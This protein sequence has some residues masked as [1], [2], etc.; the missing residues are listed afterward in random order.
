MNRVVRFTKMHGLGNDFMI[1]HDHDLFHH[2]ETPFDIKALADRH[3][4]VGFDQ[5]LIFIKHDALEFECRI[6]NS[7]GSEALQCG[8]GLRCVARFIHEN[9]LTDTK[10]F[11]IKT[12]AGLFP[13]L[14]DSYDQIRIEIGI[15]E[16]KVQLTQYKLTTGQPFP[17]SLIS[18]GNQH[19]IVKVDTL[20]H[21]NTLR[22]A[23]S[24]ANR[25]VEGINIG[26]MEVQNAHHIRLQTI[27]RGVGETLACGSNACAAVAAG[28]SNGWLTTP[29]HVEFQKGMLCIE[30]PDQQ[31]PMALIGPAS[32]VYNGEISV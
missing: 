14:I 19:A 27:E 6:F 12:K 1:I 13:I 17:L 16:V 2:R 18:T 21:K 11:S 23:Q 7:D 24:I 32:Q 15:P 9:K 5:A 10:S 28:I 30:W 25:H 31:A 3:T 22:F 26:F 4:G 20:N 29:V 8:N